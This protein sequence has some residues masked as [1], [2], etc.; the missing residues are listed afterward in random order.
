MTRK[1][2]RPRGLIPLHRDTES[3][4]PVALVAH[5]LHS[6]F[7]GEPVRTLE[8]LAMAEANRL[9]ARAPR[10]RAQV[11]PAPRDDRAYAA[12]RRIARRALSGALEDPVGEATRYHREDASPL[13]A[14]DLPPLAEVGGFLFYAG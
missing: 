5:R 1:P 8:A 10:T 14:R 2:A 13:W 12:C 9:A 7:P 3:D 4:D 6:R 11:P